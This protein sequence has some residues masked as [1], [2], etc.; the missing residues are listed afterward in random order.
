MKTKTWMTIFSLPAMCGL[1]L[2][3]GCGKKEE[4][5][6]QPA[7]TP[8]AAPAATPSDRARSIET[9]GKETHPQKERR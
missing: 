3:A 6:E 4:T 1:V 7:A 5:A 9:R 2:L 8:T